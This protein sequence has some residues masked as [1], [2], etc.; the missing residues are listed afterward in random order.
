MKKIFWLVLVL[1]LTGC[2]SQIMSGFVGKPITAVIGQYGFPA[3]T[4]DVDKNKRAFVWQMNNSVV[5]PGSSFTSGTIIGNQMFANTYTSPAYASSS[6]CSYVM[7]A[8]KTRQ[9]IEGPAA[10]TIVG[11]EKP[12]GS[13]E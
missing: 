5:I 2:A 7:Y 6:A 1:F 8:E 3:G 9:D 13:C 4:Y 11:F 12:R 10:W